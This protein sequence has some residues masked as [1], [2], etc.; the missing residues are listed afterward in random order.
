M[1]KTDPIPVIDDILDHQQNQM[2][3]SPWIYN[4]KNLSEKET[5]NCKLYYEFI[6][7]TEFI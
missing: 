2:L 3:K 7:L 5:S 1:K 6:K 4:F